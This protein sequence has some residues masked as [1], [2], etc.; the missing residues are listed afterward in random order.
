[1]NPNRSAALLA[2]VLVAGAL[3]AHKAALALPNPFFGGDAGHRMNFASS[4]VAPLDNRIWLPFLQ[5]HV[6]GAYHL[7]LPVPAY[8]LIPCVYFFVAVLF[9]GRIALGCAG[10]ARGGGVFALL[11]MGAFAYHITVAPCSVQL[12]QEIVSSALFFYLIQA[13]ALELR[14]RKRLVLIAWAALLTREIFWIYLLVLTVLRFRRIRADRTLRLAFLSFWSIP[15]LWLLSIPLGYLLFLGRFPDIPTEWP[16][17]INKESDAALSSLWGSA[18]HLANSLAV[19]GA[20]SLAAA[21]GAAAA[22]LALGSRRTAPG[23]AAP[24]D[25][26]ALAARRLAP[27]SLLSLA[28]AYGL[29]LLFDPWQATGGSGRLSFTLLEH[30]FV[31]CAILYGA[32]ARLVASRAW[33]V[34][35]IL[36]AGLLAGLSLDRA[37]WI[38]RDHAEARRQH[39]EIRQLVD[40]FAQRRLPVVA[41]VGDEYWSMVRRFIAPT[42]RARRIFYPDA[43]AET[44]GPADIL[45]IR[46]TSPHRPGERYAWHADY[47]LEGERYELHVRRPLPGPIHAAHPK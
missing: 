7:R 8:V 33:L 11:L 23:P 22:A 41:F 3:F 45:V 26:V 39:A 25:P 15:V 31:W 47:T 27:F 38:P 21:L 14:K 35:A 46:A 32:S 29:I 34:R 5:L 44:G 4:P 28:I 30:G 1:M 36:G 16:L 18:A 43:P 20:L 6:A 40:R 9:L 2:V 17:T 12:Y 13:G 42:L 10:R 19:S 37:T 24:A